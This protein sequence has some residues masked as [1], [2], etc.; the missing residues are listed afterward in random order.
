MRRS[1]PLFHTAYLFKYFCF[2]SLKVPYNPV[3]L[4]VRKYGS[5]NQAQ[6]NDGKNS[7]LELTKTS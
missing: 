2:V 3:N 7:D 1:L 5:Y 4:I 6:L